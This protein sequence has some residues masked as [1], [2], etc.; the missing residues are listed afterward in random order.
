MGGVKMTV[1][2]TTDGSKI[3]VRFPYSADLVA[4]VKRV[5]G[6]R[7]NPDEKI[8]RVPLTMDS[9]RA[10]RRVFGSALEIAPPLARY[11]RSELEHEA[12]LES[13]RTGEA[14]S[15]ARTRERS[16]ALF[17]AMDARPYQLMG[18]SFGVNA[19]QFC[20]GDQPGLG[21]TLQTLAILIEA[22][23]QP[24]LV[25]CPRTATRSVW[26]RETNEWAP[27]IMPFIA[28]GTHAQREQV[29]QAFSEMPYSSPK[30]LII[31]HE[32]LR[33]KR[34]QQCMIKG[35]RSDEQT[36][37]P[38]GSCKGNHDHKT[39]NKPEWPFLFNGMWDAVILDESHNLLASTYNVG[40]KHITLGR[41]GAM[42]VRKKIAPDGLAIAL[43][44]TPFLSKLTN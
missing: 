19:K 13:A 18:A 6:A 22:G 4:S 1:Q 38:F 7:W 14:V 8:W 40:S 17:A 9:C 15:L 16:P 20:L 23:S 28:Q 10:L 2:V 41:Y 39:I 30:M 37:L 11:A 44:R 43:S 5:S 34:L 35:F 36:K 25:S 33:V 42:Q 31:N 26:M 21:K 3:L 27:Q 24:I 32:M 12:T 29:M